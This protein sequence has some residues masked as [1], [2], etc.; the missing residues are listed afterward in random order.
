MAKASREGF[1]QRPLPVLGKVAVE[2]QRGFSFEQSLKGDERGAMQIFGP[3]S[4]G[5]GK[6]LSEAGS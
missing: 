2:I 4:D 5:R 6:A 1:G 3:Q